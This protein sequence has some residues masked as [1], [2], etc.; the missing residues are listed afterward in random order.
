MPSPLQ[1]DPV[2][3][4]HIQSCTGF[5]SLSCMLACW[6]FVHPFIS[7]YW[8]S[9]FLLLI[10]YWHSI[11]LSSNQIIYCL[12][13]SFNEW[14]RFILAYPDWYSLFQYCSGLFSLSRMFACWVFAHLAHPFIFIRT[15]K[16][17]HLRAGANYTTLLIS[18]FEMFV[19]T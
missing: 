13:Q 11:S 18:N 1:P 4:W 3:Y 14:S 17:L 12:A 5:F 16:T 7:L 2:L 10:I 15:P 6:V 9:L 19:I 8:L